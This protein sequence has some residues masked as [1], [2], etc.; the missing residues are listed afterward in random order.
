MDQQFDHLSDAQ[1]ENY[2][3]R[4]GAG[5]SQPD[6][7]LDQAIE[8]HLAAC[9]GCRIRV[10]EFHR[11]RLALMDDRLP[12]AASAPGRAT[13]N[14]ASSTSRDTGSLTATHT[15][16]NGASS[17]PSV[18]SRRSPDCPN[19]DSLRDLAAGVSS[20][21]EAA[22]LT[23]HAA[24][25]DHCGPILRAYTEDF[26]DDL[27]PEDQSLLNQLNSASPSWQK[28]IAARMA[29]STEGASSSV[30]PVLEPSARK[31]D[32][33]AQHPSAVQKSGIP[34]G[35]R[36]IFRLPSLKWLLVPVTAIACALIAF[37]IWNAQ[38]ETPEKVEKLLAQA[39][40]EQRTME[41]RWPGADYSPMRVTRGPEDSRFNKP[42]PLLEAEGIISRKQPDRSDDVQWLQAEA[43]AEILEH[44][45]QAAIATLDKALQNHP[46]STPLM[47]DS[48][49]AYFQLAELSKDDQQYIRAADLLSKILNLDPRN[50]TALY[51][52]ALVLE[53]MHVLDRAASDW[54]LVLQIEK[55]P[56][57]KEEAKRHLDMLRSRSGIAPKSRSEFA[58][59]RI[60]TDLALMISSFPKWR[61]DS[62]DRSLRR[63]TYVLAD[64]L[65]KQHGDTWL[66]DLLRDGV[67]PEAIREL[68]NAVEANHDGRYARALAA[69]KVAAEKFASEGNRSGALR[70]RYEN[71]YAFQRALRGTQCAAKADAL[72]RD[73]SETH[74]EWLLAQVLIERAICHNLA[75]NLQDSQTMIHEAR[76]IS[77]RANFPV[78]ELRAIGISAGIAR[79][80]GQNQKAWEL[81]NEGLRLYWESSYPKE[82]LF[83]FYVV[84]ALTSEGRGH[85]ALAE[86]LQRQA[87]AVVKHE[88]DSIELGAARLLLA[89][90]LAAENNQQEAEAEVEKADALFASTPKEPTANTYKITGNTRL[91]RFRLQ[92]NHPR[93]ALKLLQSVKALVPTVQAYAVAL[94]FFVVEGDTQLKLGNITPAKIDYESAVNVAEAALP[95]VTQEQ[96][97]VKWMNEVR[98]AYCGLTRV[99]LSQGMS[100]DALRV[101]ETYRGRMLMLPRIPTP[102]NASFHPLAL[103]NGGTLLKPNDPHIA[104]V[105]YASFDDG[106]QIWLSTQH[107]VSSVWS[108]IAKQDF[109]SLAHNFERDCSTPTS[110]LSS[111]QQEGRKLFS[112]LL[113]P[114]I[115]QLTGI[116]TVVVEPDSD[117]DG[118]PFEAMW[119]QEGFA[120]EKYSFIYSRAEGE[121]HLLRD[122]FPLKR[123]DS[124]TILDGS[125]GPGIAELP[126]VDIEER[127]ILHAFPRAVVME[128]SRVTPAQADRSIAS[129]RIVHFTGHAVQEGSGSALIFGNQKL[130]ARNFGSWA[131][132]KAELVVLSACS[133]SLGT[134]D[135]ALD[136][137]NLV[138][139]LLN[140]GVPLVIATRWNVDSLSA[141]ELMAEF[142]DDLDEGEPLTQSLKRARQKMIANHPHPYYW[143]A[144]AL[145]GRAS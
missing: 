123:S 76:L 14:G 58:P 36:S 22:R 92:E 100:L 81:A 97:R 20:N 61:K 94:N 3:D 50:S 51:N 84:M 108:E 39:Y 133:S 54:N 83:Q 35:K 70:A 112:L 27:S 102:R 91:A 19:E 125:K 17:A 134:E 46:G 66:H 37:F 105:I 104:R 73:V 98:G 71:V 82:R 128:G 140:L 116:E 40:T 69:S 75:G 135:G 47:L 129:S 4:T 110:S 32:G 5:R 141:A 43:R 87:I 77:E 103:L 30:S 124:V 85:Y 2:G 44:Q 127:A 96:A 86:V 48:A 115:P 25:C 42:A 12:S 28:K 31:P 93:A 33:V 24:Q 130:T 60:E 26:S 55:S 49:I 136:Q 118:L 7:A 52:R 65:Q 126:G 90:F 138:A 9:A 67:N 89:D 132:E 21:E 63:D 59:E 34:S 68:S 88:S 41:M 10:L 57:W 142:Y 109:V 11:A 131:L 111:V 15:N 8:T 119:S 114:L 145:S 107:G 74:Y 95:T 53:R 1:I 78:T 144:F 117:L 13:S 29:A 99:L 72:W 113:E 143:A 16:P 139:A 121:D 64:V 6:H 38:R 62:T 101:W 45:P 18:F 106:I 23:Q 79:Q 80:Q 122:F 120:G 56:G 137:D